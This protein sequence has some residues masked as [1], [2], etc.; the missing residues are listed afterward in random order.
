VATRAGYETSQGSSDSLAA[1]CA[2]AHVQSKDVVAE[3]NAFF[4]PCSYT[5]DPFAKTGSGQ[6]R[7]NS[8][9]NPIEQKG[10]FFSLQVKAFFNTKQ[11]L[12]YIWR[13]Q[14]LQIQGQGRRD[15]L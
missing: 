4:E 12:I 15:V 10:V 5:N 9:K 14:A 3:N 11:T 8:N 2:V 6:T 1:G 13:E 7:E